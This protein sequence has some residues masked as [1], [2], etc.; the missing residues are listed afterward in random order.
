MNDILLLTTP[1]VEGIPVE[2]YFGIITANQVAG[3]GFF[4]DLTAYFLICS[5]VNLEHIVSP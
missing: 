3:T 2:K 5:A 1:S 4:T